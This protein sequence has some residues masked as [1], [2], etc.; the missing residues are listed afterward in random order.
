MVT[1]LCSIARSCCVK[2]SGG[3]I[4]DF[5]VSISSTAAAEMVSGAH[6]AGID[7]CVVDG[8]CWEEFSRSSIGLSTV[9]VSLAGA[10]DEGLL[11]GG[12]SGVIGSD[13]GAAS[14]AGSNGRNS[15]LEV[16]IGGS[17][18]P[19]TMPSPSA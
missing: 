12:I 19:S 11:G 3:G 2:L 9:D 8:L 16:S 14:I 10:W 7:D 6:H 4:S 13:E 15:A 1:G 17:A 5:E 18:S